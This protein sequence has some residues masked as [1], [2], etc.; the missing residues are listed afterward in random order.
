MADGRGRAPA[1]QE[2]RCLPGCGGGD[3]VGNSP[4]RMRSLG[5]RRR[6]WRALGGLR[7]RDSVQASGHVV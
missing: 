4:G 1:G 3:G 6:A 2:D 7:A 5:R